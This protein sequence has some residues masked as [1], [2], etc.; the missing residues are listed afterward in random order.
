MLV[1]LSDGKCRSCSAQ[2]E[3][4]GADGI[5]D[6]HAAGRH[7]H[8]TGLIRNGASLPEAQKLARHT[9]IKMTMK[10]THIGM[11]DQAK[12]I[13]RLSWQRIG[14]GKNVSEGQLVALGDTKQVEE[15]PAKK[16]ENPCG[17]RGFDADRQSM[18]P[19]VK[20]GEK[21]RRRESNPRPEMY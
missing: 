4:V 9:D 2:L 8:I 3:I 21:W 20:S 7:S 5:A 10:Y 18:S 13:R 15:A 12:A 17:D 6:F 14:S 1:E 11:D 19:D 16:S